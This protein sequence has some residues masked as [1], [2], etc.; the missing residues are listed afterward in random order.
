MRAQVI[1]GVTV[2]ACQRDRFSVEGVIV[3]SPFHRRF[4]AVQR[5][6]RHRFSV[7]A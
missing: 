4:I 3:S 1:Q 7:T 5:G 6:G 2:S